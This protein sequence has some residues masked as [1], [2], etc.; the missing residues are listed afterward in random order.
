[1]KRKIY[2]KQKTFKY[3]SLKGTVFFFCNKNEDGEMEFLTQCEKRQGQWHIWKGEESFPIYKGDELDM[4]I[5]ENNIKE[6]IK[7]KENIE[8]EIEFVGLK[9]IT[10]N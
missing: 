1:M 6:Q 10:N 2:I 3:A 8:T 4:N 9:K 5:I 7:E